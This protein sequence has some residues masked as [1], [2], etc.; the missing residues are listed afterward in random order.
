MALVIAASVFMGDLIAALALLLRGEITSRFVA[1]SLAVL[2]LSG[3]VFSYYFG[4]L[5]KTDA[6]QPGRDRRMAILSSVMVA[7]LVVIGFTQLGP[8]SAQRAFRADGQKVQRLYDFSTVVSEYWRSHDHQLPEITQLAY[9]A[10]TDPIT[11]Q[12]YEYQPGNGSRYQLC[13]TFTRASDPRQET[14]PTPSVW[15]HPAGHHCFSLDA[16]TAAD[17]PPQY[18]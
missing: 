9:S 6:A 14:A 15:V 13:T 11:R 7:I 18:P 3:G 2:V 8:P 16:G 5:R 17:F 4:G 10:V 1:K 12:Q